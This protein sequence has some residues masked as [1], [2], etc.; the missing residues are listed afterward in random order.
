ME[1]G[2]SD[3]DPLSMPFGNCQFDQDT[4]QRSKPQLRTT[5][6]F[7]KM[8][9]DSNHLESNNKGKP[10][11][12]WFLK[13]LVDGGCETWSD[14]VGSDNS[15]NFDEKNIE[16]LREHTRTCTHKENRKD[17]KQSTQTHIP[18]CPLKWLDD[19]FYLLLHHIIKN[20]ST[21]PKQHEVGPTVIHAQKLHRSPERSASYHLLD[22]SW[23]LITMY[24]F[25][26]LSFQIL[27]I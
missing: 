3:K 9:I 26:E 12:L 24:S 25:G 17:I 4:H 19:M 5:G 23:S 2:N 18:Q 21:S 10:S 27:R 22:Q 13:Y 11:F 15:P 7:N 16:K 20:C 1:L 14:V 8:K 6:K